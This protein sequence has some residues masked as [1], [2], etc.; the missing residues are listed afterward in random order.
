M[1]YYTTKVE[2]FWVGETCKEMFLILNAP[3]IGINWSYL[4]AQGRLLP[5]PQ[6]LD[7]ITPFGC[8]PRNGQF[9]IYSG[10]LPPGDYDLYI[11]IDNIHNGHLDLY[12]NSLTYSHL[13]IHVI[14]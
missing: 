10:D 2:N 11:G 14:K 13:M 1:M 7:Q 12:N 6:Y 9:P 4:N 3:V 8:L 5:L